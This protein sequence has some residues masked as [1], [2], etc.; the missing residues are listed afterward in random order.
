MTQPTNY[1][2]VKLGS[3][4]EFLRG[5]CSATLLAPTSG[6]ENYPNLIENLPTHRYS[7]VHVVS[8]LKSLLVQFQEMKLDQSLLAAEAFRPM[9]KEMED[10]LQQAEANET[11]YLYN[12]FAE[13]LV[14]LS[15]QVFSTVKSELNKPISSAHETT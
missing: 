11:S 5:V 8:V 1:Q 3:N 2:F 12:P 9:I 14:A 6:L 13:R 7:V 10:H 4:L 15:K